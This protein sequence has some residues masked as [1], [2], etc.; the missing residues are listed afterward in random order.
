MCGIFCLNSDKEIKI[1]LIQG[2]Q[3]L[4]YRGYDS[5][6]L[7][8][9]NNSK[10]TTVKSLGRVLNL[11]TKITK[12]KKD[13]TIGIGHTR[14][15]T[16]GKSNLSNTHPIYN[17]GVAIVHN[18]IVVNHKTIK[19]YLIKLKYKFNGET[20]TE[21]ILNL[22]QYYTDLKFDYLGALKKTINKIQGNYAIA[23]I[24][25]TNKRYIFC[26]KNGSPLFIGYC[27]SDHYISSDINALALFVNKVITLEDGD[28]GIVGKNYLKII[29]NH[30]A[31]RL[32]SV[33]TGSSRRQE[34]ILG[35]IWF[36]GIKCTF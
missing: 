29:T 35:K 7:T 11:N 12:T 4:E 28:I 1:K 10:F 9:I 36:G 16:H 32:Y 14:W 18:G 20:D 2:L 21:V 15:A 6:G 8:F 23:V 26:A 31:K 22:I 34:I 13:G 30:G 25:S 33:K 27:R 17:N 5:A 3:F 19:N 24:F